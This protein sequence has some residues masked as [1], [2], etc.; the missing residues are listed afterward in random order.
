MRH[1]G[2]RDSSPAR[3]ERCEPFQ[4][5]EKRLMHQPERAMRFAVDRDLMF[6]NVRV[7]ALKKV[8]KR[9]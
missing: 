3:D 4:R 1:C 7:G 2:E 8:P 5:I 9:K 6:L